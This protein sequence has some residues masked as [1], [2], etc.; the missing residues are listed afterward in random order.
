MNR[1]V[2]RV[3]KRPGLPCWWVRVGGLEIPSARQDSAVRAAIALARKHCD[4][5]GLAQ[6]VLHGKD[7]R[8]RWERS[9]P[10]NTPRRKG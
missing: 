1:V 9:Y 4:G 5:G 7:G 10:D 6:V 2:I 8:I 3:Q